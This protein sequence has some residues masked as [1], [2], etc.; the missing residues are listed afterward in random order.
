MSDQPAMNFERVLTELKEFE[1]EHQERLETTWSQ[2][3]NFNMKGYI[4]GRIKNSPTLLHLIECGTT[5]DIL[6]FYEGLR[7]TV[8]LIAIDVLM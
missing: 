6:T 5:D 1:I 7:E 8:P 4:E 3:D 2:A